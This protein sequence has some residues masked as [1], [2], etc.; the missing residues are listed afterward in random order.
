MWGMKENARAMDDPVP[1]RRTELDRVLW[2]IAAM[3]GG[4]IVYLACTL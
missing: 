3:I 2:T 4:A 1:S